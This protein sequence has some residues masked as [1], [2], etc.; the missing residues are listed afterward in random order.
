MEFKITKSQRIDL[1]VGYILLTGVL[2][3]ASFLLAGIFWSWAATGS[4]ELHYAISGTNLFQFWLADIRQI[5]LGS[6]Q[7]KLLINVGLALLLITP[8]IRVAASVLYFAFAERN[9]KY[10]FF[11]GF[12]LTVLSYSL[13][14]R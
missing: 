1:I 7:P 8:Y 6:F 10:T 9:V 13:F 14:L 2:L 11:T 3:S 4:P 5:S 12:V